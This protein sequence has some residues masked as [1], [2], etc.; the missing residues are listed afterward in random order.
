MVCFSICAYDWYVWVCVP[1]TVHVRVIFLI[2]WFFCCCFLCS[3]PDV[4]VHHLWVHFSKSTLLINILPF[5]LIC[6]IHYTVLYTTLNP[7]VHCTVYWTVYKNWHTHQSD[8]LCIH[9]WGLA[10]FRRNPTLLASYTMYYSLSSTL[11]YSILWTVY[12]ILHWSLYCTLNFIE[13]TVE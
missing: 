1:V 2:C 3:L 12:R 6:N 5:N 11:Y 4:L 9:G 10:Y 8:C 13:F 7:T